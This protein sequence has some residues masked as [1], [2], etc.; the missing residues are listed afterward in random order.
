MSRDLILISAEYKNGENMQNFQIVT[1]RWRIG[2]NLVSK[3][4]L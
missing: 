3:I 2:T 1:D 4:S